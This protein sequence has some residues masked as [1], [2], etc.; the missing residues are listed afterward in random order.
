MA[1]EG[2]TRAELARKLGVSRAWVTK[3]LGRTS[4]DRP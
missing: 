3:V 2:L 1:A 4:A